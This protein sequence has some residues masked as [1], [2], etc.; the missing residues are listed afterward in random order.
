MFMDAG[1]A[2][3]MRR[4][5][6]LAA[7]LVL[8]L[9]IPGAGP[10]A[11]ST[12]DRGLAIGAPAVMQ[13]LRENGYRNVGVLSFRVRSGDSPKAETA[14][15]LSQSLAAR[16]EVALVLVEDLKNPVG[17][18]RIGGTRAAD[19]AARAALFAS[20]YP[21]A[22]GSEQVK[23]DAFLSGEAQL[24]PDLR[25]LTVSVEVFDARGGAPREVV[26]F[27]AN[28]DSPTLADAGEPFLTR[29]GF[30]NR[31]FRLKKEPPA[32]A[33]VSATSK[34][35]DSGAQTTRERNPLLAPD[36]PVSLEVR[37]DGHAVPFQFADGEAFIDEPRAGQAVEFVVRRRR[38]DGL[39][40]GV[41][42]AVNGAN[43]LFREKKPSPE[44]SKW[45]LP[46]GAAPLHIRGYQVEGRSEAE[47]FRVL[48]DTE[49]PTRAKDF[50]GDAGIINLVVFRAKEGMPDVGKRPQIDQIA[51]REA[52]ISRGALPERPPTNLFGMVAAVR[53]P[54]PQVRGLIVEGEA[55]NSAVRGA[56]ANFEENP[57]MSAAIRYYTAKH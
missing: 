28:A 30:P 21:L 1:G 23:A 45:L 51:R 19:P 41:V 9:L 15:L 50:G 22:W 46:P 48:S 36:A 52:L 18:V 13:F 25:Y 14:A 37:Y 16:L 10:P 27:T 43:T 11:P 57:E 35:I 53:N 12:I 31:T 20:H 26:R 6:G 54:E 32:A 34:P 56:Q 55:I 33:A 40:Y 3:R 47:A 42:L 39:R 29:G 24:S 7:G 5:G 44:C 38:D 17:I 2:S 8:F 49:S 4:P